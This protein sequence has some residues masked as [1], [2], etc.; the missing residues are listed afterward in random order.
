MKIRIN[1]ICLPVPTGL[2]FNRLTL[3]AVRKGLL[4][5]T[6]MHSNALSPEASAHLL[7]ELRRVKR[8]RGTWE[9]VHVQSA[10]GDDIRIEL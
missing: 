1:S 8:L 10:D 4:H 6:G 7:Q 5:G 9:L 3:W 2:V